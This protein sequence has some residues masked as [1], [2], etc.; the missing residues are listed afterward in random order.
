MVA[1]FAYFTHRMDHERAHIQVMPCFRHSDEQGNNQIF[2]HLLNTDIV[3]A[4]RKHDNVI[5]KK[6]LMLDLCDRCI[7]VQKSAV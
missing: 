6:Y 5:C 2:F 1:Y 7:I 4:K 3:H